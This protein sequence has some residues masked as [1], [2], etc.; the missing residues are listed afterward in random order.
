MKILKA[1]LPHL[2]SI[3]FGAVLVIVFF[4]PLFFENKIIDQNDIFQGVG[5]G[6]EAIQYRNETGEE[7]L[8]T[9]S[10]FS[11]MPAY[12]INTAFSGELIKYVHRLISFGMPPT[13]QVIFL[14]YVCFYLLLITF[15][16][17]PLLAAAGAVAYSFNT[18]NLVSV[19]AGHIWKV[20]AIAYMPL[21]VAG[22]RVISSGENR[23][24]GV[25]LLSTAVA[26]ELYSNHL[27]I[28]YYLFLFLLVFGIIE[29]IKTVRDKSWNI[30]S[31][32]VAMLLIAAVLGIG[33]NAARLWT[34]MEYSTYSTRGQSEL[35][36]ST[37][38]TSQQ[39]GLEKDYVFN[40]SYGVKESLT[41]LIPNFSGG[42]SAMPL[43]NDSNLWNALSGRGM[44]PAQIR[45]QVSRVPTYW[46]DQPSVAGPSYVG[47]II[48]F[49]VV[50]SWFYVEKP[51]RNWLLIAAAFGLLLSWGKN[52]EAFN[53]LMYD[54]F[55][56]YRK[57]RS[58]SMAM[59]ILLLSLPL[60]GIL[61]LDRFL[62]SDAADKDKKLL[63]S[64][65]IVAGLCAFIALFAGALF[66]FSGAIDSRLGQLP[67]WYVSAIRLDRKA[68][69]V[70][71]GFRSIFFI[72]IALASIWVF[73]KGKISQTVFGLLIVLLT[74]AD[75]VMV[76]NRFFDDAKYIRS[77][78]RHTIPASDS[79][80][81]IMRLAGDS[82]YRVLNL[83]DPFNEAYTS[84]YHSS[85]GGY[86]GAKM[87]KYNELISYGISGEMSE[88]I[89]GLQ[90][91]EMNFE[92]YYIINM[93]NT[94]FFKY[95]PAKENI[96]PNSSAFGN[97]WFANEV[98]HAE[99]ADQ[100]MALLNQLK[101]Q[102]EVVVNKTKYGEVSSSYNGSGT[103]TLTEY[104]PNKL[105]YQSESAENGLAVFSEIYYP[106]GW[107]ATID[108][109]EAPILEANYVLRALEVPAGKHE[110]IFKF[111]PASYRIGNLLT[112]IMSVLMLGVLGFGVFRSVQ[113][114]S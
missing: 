103:I 98:R 108:G 81:E 7:A 59:V 17:H 27:Q 90:G 16:V 23:W 85:I 71:D 109:E 76:G 34:T 50:L 93:L 42:A 86:H 22:V 101:S 58:V 41:L 112:L 21:V 68:M 11:G 66:D 99:N 48:L 67:D 9:N 40:W 77:T 31:R 106:K 10:M 3:T 35:T 87:K 96:L 64:G 6:E 53:Y 114:L 15:G 105:T 20:R 95:G 45:E 26:L 70:S 55:P 110:V 56:A 4:S 60:L 8:W 94:Q 107:T 30:F 111:D 36:A 88:M 14:A 63:I 39:S 75:F 97:A 74:A 89:A 52:F 28:T 19:E 47:A 92:A 44:G 18:F 32:N 62:K 79:D 25:G 33:A 73:M 2:I 29:I 12:L 57:F 72:A 78:G 46:G 91:G 38:G 102:Q 69:L 1:A 13:A 24:L 82:H 84:T 83:Q 49:L 54:Y 100:E 51:V 5:A 37:T 61:G 113:E 43:D 104:R 80:R 65:G